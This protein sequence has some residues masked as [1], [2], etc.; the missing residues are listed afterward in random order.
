ME[1]VDVFLQRQSRRQQ[2]LT[3]QHSVRHGFEQKTISRIVRHHGSTLV[4]TIQVLELVN[5]NFLWNFPCFLK[6]GVITKVAFGPDV[7]LLTCTPGGRGD[8]NSYIEE[9]KVLLTHS[10]WSLFARG[11]LFLGSSVVTVSGT[12]LLQ[13]NLNIPCLT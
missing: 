4:Y 10:K 2:K 7:S 8:R 5:E 3:K 6:Q 1:K 13:D 9:G 12:F 11:L